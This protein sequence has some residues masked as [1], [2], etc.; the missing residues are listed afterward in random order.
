MSELGAQDPRRRRARAGPRRHGHRESRSRSARRRCCAS[1]SRIPG[2]RASSA[3]PDRRAP[4]RAR[5]STRS[6]AALRGAGQDRRRSSPSIPPAP[7]PAAR[8]WATASACRS[9][10]PIP[11][12]SSAP[13][14]PAA[15][16]R[17]GARHRRHGAPAGRRRHDFVLIETVG[18]GQDEVD[19]VR[20]AQTSRSS[21]WC[22]AWA[23]TCRRSRPASWRSPTSSSSTRPTSPAPTAW[24]AS[25]T[26]AAGARPSS[27]RWRRREGIDE[28]LAG[29]R[30]CRS[31]AR[32]RLGCGN[33]GHRSSGHRGDQSG[34]RPSLST[35]PLACR[36][37]SRDR[38]HRK[39]S[40]R[41]AACR[42]LADRTARA[43]APDSPISK[44]LEKRGAGL[45]HVALKVPDLDAAV[46]R[47]RA[48]ARGC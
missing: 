45:H 39:G 35:N 27:A 6:R 13:W 23:T 1:C 28:L 21:C 24:S 19:I 42:G 34:R 38:G 33:A 9:T 37:P 14:P 25:C 29:H 30:T 5:W 31:A 2:T 15:A 20:L 7:S 44:F 3:S 32:W 48:Q 10:T 8:S 12:S 46:G 43:S 26:R 40:R 36:R 18:V 22:P 17:P 11:A 16:R 47:L 4:A 41:D